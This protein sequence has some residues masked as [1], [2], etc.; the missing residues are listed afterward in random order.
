ME[1][2][3]T[4]G[5]AFAQA[6]GD[7]GVPYIGV[8][9]GLV[10]DI[11]TSCEKV[12]LHKRKCRMLAQKAASLL[13]AVTCDPSLDNQDAREMMDE[14]EAV[15]RMVYSRVNVWSRYN[16]IE[17]WWK[18]GEIDNGLQDLDQELN[19][20]YQRFTIRGQLLN[21]RANERL[22]N[23]IRNEHAERREH[24]AELK[25]AVLSILKDPQGLQEAARMQ[26]DGIPAAQRL[27]RD[28]QQQL[29]DMRAERLRGTTDDD[30]ALATSEDQTYAEVEQGLAELHH[31]TGIPPSLPRLDGQVVKL[32]NI[33]RFTGS[34]SQIWVGKWLGKTTVALKALQSI[35]LS[36]K[37]LKRFEH[38]IE[39]WY[40]LQHPHVLPLYGVVAD[41]DYRDYIVAPWQDNGNLFDY[42][43]R[44]RTADRTHLLLGAA[45]GLEY[46]H[47]KDVIHGNVRCA[48]ILVNAKGEACICDFGMAKAIED[49][50][51]NPASA[52]LTKAGS[53]RWLAPELIENEEVTSPTQATDIYSFAMAML[54]C[55]TLQVPFANL[56]RDAHVIR[57]IISKKAKPARPRDPES[58][59]WITDQIWSVMQDCWQYNPKE[60]PSMSD[61]VRHIQEC[62]EPSAGNH[63]HDEDM[64][65][66]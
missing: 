14:T 32:E 64:D 25:Q 50:T 26:R 8:A 13:D 58:Q 44:N 7:L 20:A 31:L 53:A 24:D 22:F 5:L 54:E 18:D 65:C 19:T 23:T 36:E 40:Q 28:G 46:L 27:M 34:H 11:K 1:R 16:R 48:N 45:K 12:V 57:D 43:T 33:P 29:R 62:V 38:E 47:Q 61:V 35:A 3:V 21:Q 59:R 10:K 66:T 42:T 49:I 15:L 6:A 60:R 41:I 63:G 39:V 52:T 9:A 37:G 51:E 17:A 2:I 30:G 55:Y 56:K 4:V